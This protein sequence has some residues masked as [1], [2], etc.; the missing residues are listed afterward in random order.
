MQLCGTAQ[1]QTKLFKIL[2]AE[3]INL[4]Y[5]KMICMILSFAQEKG[6]DNKSALKA[7]HINFKIT[8]SAT[9]KLRYNL[10]MQYNIT[11]NNHH[12]T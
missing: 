4:Y 6:Q 9:R 1:V 7:S 2:S 3:F 10:R 8:K 5:C 11:N 12:L